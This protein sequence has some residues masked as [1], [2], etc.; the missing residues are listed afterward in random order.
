MPHT[1]PKKARLK[2]QK[3]IEALFARGRRLVV[4]PLRVQ[5]LLQRKEDAAAAHVQVAVSVPKKV[6]KKAVHR[7]RIKRLMREAWRLQKGPLEQSLQQKELH[8]QVFI[9]YTS[10][11]LPTFDGVYEKMT[12]VLQKLQ[13]TLPA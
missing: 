5:Y 10:P 7:N 12:A 1:L 9:I 6:F 8:L 2:K 3:A 4:P 13:T 11:E